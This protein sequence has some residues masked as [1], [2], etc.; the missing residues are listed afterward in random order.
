LPFVGRIIDTLRAD[1]SAWSGSGLYVGCGN[2]R[3][4]LPLLDAGLNLLGLD[5]SPEALRRLTQR[6]PSLSPQRLVREDFRTFKSRDA[7]F[8]YLVAIQVFQHGDDADVGAYF[9]NAATLL[10]P[11]GL[12]FLRVNSIN[13]NLYR[14]HT[15]VEH[16]AWGGFTVRYE[17]GPKSGL[18]VHFYSQ[19]E[20]LERLKVS[21]IPLMPPREEVITRAAPP[22][23][24]WAQ[25]DA[26]WRR[27]EPWD[28]QANAEPV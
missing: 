9:E 19:S 18:L 12:F 10:R 21:F 25:W 17:E 24:A 23:G 11:G 7:R 26:I 22:A 4:Y 8:D 5:V 28:R 1:P 3:N 2:G 20:L 16:N 15:V 6:R 13:T 14:A 27:R